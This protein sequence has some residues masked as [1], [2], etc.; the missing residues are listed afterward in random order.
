MLAISHH[1]VEDHV[2]HIYRKLNIT[3]RP[4]AALRAKNLGL[5]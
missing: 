4:E 3:S 2:K 1:T 5:L